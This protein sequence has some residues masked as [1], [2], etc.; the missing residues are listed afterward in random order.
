MLSGSDEISGELSFEVLPEMD[1][2][3]GK[4]LYHAMARFLKVMENFL[5]LIAPLTLW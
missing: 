5:H 3:R 2:L 4:L 1:G